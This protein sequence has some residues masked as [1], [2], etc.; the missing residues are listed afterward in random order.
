VHKA[1]AAGSVPAAVRTKQEAVELGQGE[2]APER[3]GSADGGRSVL[4]A[5]QLVWRQ[6]PEVGSEALARVHDG[7]SR[8]ARRV[9]EPASRPDRRADE[10]D[11][12]P[13]RGEVAP[14]LEEVPLHVDQEQRD[15]VRR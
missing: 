3:A 11:V 10:L 8:R 14:G 7:Q 12:I 1:S 13:H 15:A 2:E 6:L 5:F 4:D 9:E